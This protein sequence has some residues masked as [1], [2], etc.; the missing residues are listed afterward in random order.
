LSWHRF[1]DIDSEHL[2]PGILITKTHPDY[3]STEQGNKDW[4]PAHQP[5]PAGLE[6]LIMIPLDQFGDDE[7]QFIRLIEDFFEDIRNGLALN[8]LRASK[9]DFRGMQRNLTSRFVEAFE[10]KPGVAGLRFDIKKFMEG[11]RR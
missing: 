6:D 2:L 5:S 1:G 3:F 9:Y 10:I 8:S 4:P 11:R 7:V